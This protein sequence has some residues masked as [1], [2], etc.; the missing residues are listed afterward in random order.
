[1]D[2][3]E[4]L[5]LLKERGYKYTD[6]REEMLRFFSKKNKYLT[7]RDVLAWMKDDYPGISF[8]TIYRNLSLFVELGIFE[9]TELSGEKHFRYTCSHDEHHH[10]FICLHC[11]KTKEIA[12]CPMKELEDN[13]KGYDISGHKFEIYGRCP[14]CHM[15]SNPI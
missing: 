1:M 8:D 5:Q 11:G 3:N 7:A 2:V 15:E 13:L 10:H 12:T 14:E 6:K 4:A 9:M